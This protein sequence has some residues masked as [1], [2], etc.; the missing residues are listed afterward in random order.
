MLI[1]EI[2]SFLRPL[3]RAAGV[4]FS[5]KMP[6]LENSSFVRP[7]VRATGVLFSGKCRFLI[8]EPEILEMK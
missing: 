1:L 6:I 8:C 2:S 7:L 5:G 3:V 4:L